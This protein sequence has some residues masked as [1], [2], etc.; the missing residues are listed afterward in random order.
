M[1]GT[2]VCRRVRSLKIVCNVFDADGLYR[3]RT[4]S[5]TANATGFV[6]CDCGTDG[7]DCSPGK[8]EPDRLKHCRS[9]ARE[10]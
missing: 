2:A 7:W 6:R 8:F 5:H 1:T 4:S 10:P 3:Y 9:S